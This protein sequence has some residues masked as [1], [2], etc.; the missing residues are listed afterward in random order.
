MKKTLLPKFMISIPS[1]LFWVAVATFD[2][3]MQTA[4]ALTAALLHETGHIAVIRLCGMRLTGLTVLPYGVEMTTDRRPCSFYEDL[5]VNAAG[6]AVN[7]TTALPFH[8]LGSV[9]HGETG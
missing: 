6:C 8:A 7:L 1:I 5:A 4:A 9:I 3:T 2:R